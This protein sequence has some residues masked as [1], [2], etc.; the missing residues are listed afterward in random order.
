MIDDKHFDALWERAQAEKYA[1]SLAAE[2]PAWRS[3]RRR[4]AGMVAGVALLLAV[5]APIALGHQPAQ[6]IYCNN[7][8]F[9][10]SHWT[11]TANALLME[12]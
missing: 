9:G 5:S 11:E 1:E 10:D 7:A 6:R 8:A 12:A 3:R 4:N 2:Y